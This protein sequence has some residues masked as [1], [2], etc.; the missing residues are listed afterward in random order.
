MP[1][2]LFAK[3]PVRWC[4]GEQYDAI[5]RSASASSLMSTSVWSSSA[6]S[7]STSRPKSAALRLA[8]STR[9]PAAP[10]SMRLLLLLAKRAP[11][12]AL[13]LRPPR[14]PRDRPRRMDVLDDECAAPEVPGDDAGHTL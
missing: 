13:V 12:L 5:G 11:L 10:L 4:L 2:K 6:G 8:W 14:P 7:T 3:P 1:Y 9:G